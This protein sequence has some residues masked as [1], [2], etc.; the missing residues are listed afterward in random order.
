LFREEIKKEIEDFLEF[1]ENI[2]TSYPNL[3]GTMKAVLRDKFIALHAL[4]KKLERSH[5]NNL[6]AHLGA[7]EQKET[8]SPKRS[9]RQEIVKLRPEI[10][11]IET[12]KTI[13]R[14]SN[15]KSWLFKRINKID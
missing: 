15:I 13:Q 11:Q 2:D 14:I 5:T 7:L 4:V 10:K 6:T 1:N 9:R 8:N 3:W 12:K